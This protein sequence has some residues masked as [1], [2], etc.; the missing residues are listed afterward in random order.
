MRSILSFFRDDRGSQSIA[1][2]LWVP[3]FVALLVIV[4]DTTTLYITQTEMENVAR[5]TARRMV[6][7]LSADNAET[8]ARNSMTLRDYPYTVTATFDLA[9]G[10]DVTIAVQ[11]GDISIMGYLHP[12]TITSTTLGARVIMRPDPTVCYG[13]GGGGN[14]NGNGGS[15]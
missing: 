12:L 1:F 10:A 9:T 2:L 7:G 5:D 4:M 15:T 8:H 13:C 14:G 11:T 3:I 6:K